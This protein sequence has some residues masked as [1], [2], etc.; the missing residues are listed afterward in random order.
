[1]EKYIIRTLLGCGEMDITVLI[2]ELEKY[3][4]YVDL[5]YIVDYIY[6]EQ[7]QLSFDSIIYR[8]YEYAFSGAWEDALDEYNDSRLDNSYIPK[9]GYEMSD[10]RNKYIVIDCNGPCSKI[11]M[12]NDSEI[13]FKYYPK[14]FV[15]LLREKLGI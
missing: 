4:R 6:D 5:A 2:S 14:K 1:M 3:K 11:I 9:K 15:Q 8:V 13:N 12:S 7:I 10:F